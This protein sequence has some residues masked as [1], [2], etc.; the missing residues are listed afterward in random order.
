MDDT[1]G[2][3]RP[4]CKELGRSE[5][6][7]E[8]WLY[9]VERVRHNL[10]IVLAM[11]PV[12]D[13]LRIRLRMFPSIINCTT[14][15]WFQPWP[16]EAL[17]AVAENLLMLATDAV[18]GTSPGGASMV[19]SPK[20]TPT[21]PYSPGTSHQLAQIPEKYIDLEKYIDSS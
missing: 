16:A 2:L 5:A 4:V 21:Y 12:G 7:D 11:S 14:V 20:G 1:V 9:F 3:L 10:H 15:D 19:G 8:V 6:K 18:G 13:K 17:L